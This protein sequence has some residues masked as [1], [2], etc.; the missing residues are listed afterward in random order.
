MISI[1][2]N[3][4][5]AVLMGGISAE[6]QISLESGTNMAAAIAS[7]GLT[8]ITSDI[9]PDDLS[10][11]DDDSI[12]V[13]F[14]GL[15]GRFGEDGQLQEILESRNLVYT[16]SGARAS[17]NA[18][19][20]TLSKEIF[21]GSGMPLA[22][23]FCVSNSDTAENISEA[24][25]KFGDKFA[26]KPVKQGSSVGVE[27]IR[28]V[29]QAAEAAIRCFGEFGDCMVEEFIRGREITV[30]ILNGK[31]LPVTEIISKTGFY[32]YTAKYK[33]DSTEYLF[34]SVKDTAVIDKINRTA[35]ACFNSLGCRHQSRVDMILTD[36][37]V[38]YIL[39]INTLPGFTEHSLLPMAA[40]KAGISPEELCLEIIKAAL[41]NK[42]GVE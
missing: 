4:K 2:N 25:K 32:D 29:R 20:K 11:L 15:H 8:V 7:A 21:A 33:D 12:D 5:V 9:T 36:D 30:G 40:K 13:F 27:I 38:P 3:I 6:R 19:D 1:D 16:G 24:I 37:N 28:G 14:L 42:H 39:E 31:T 18:F 35:L 26:V 34:D 10:I 22:R 23:H 17:R 41:N